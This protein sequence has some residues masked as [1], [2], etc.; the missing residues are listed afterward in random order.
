MN[1]RRLLIAG[2]L[3]GAFLLPAHAQ[4]LQA[5]PPT[6]FAAFTA[7]GSFQVAL[8]A[9]NGGRYG[10]LIQNQGAHTMYVFIGSGSATT[11]NSI[12]LPPPGTNTPSVFN[13]G[14]PGGPVIQDEIQVQG[15]SSDA[16]LAVWQ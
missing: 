9:S 1:L 12:Q 16:Y 13:C 4:F 6:Q 5:A 10:C 11:G 7:N 2:L 14:S 15:T 8:A 3:L